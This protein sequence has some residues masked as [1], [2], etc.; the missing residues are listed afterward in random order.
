LNSWALPARMY[1]RAWPRYAKSAHPAFRATVSSHVES[2][3]PAQSLLARPSRTGLAAA[4]NGRSAGLNGDQAAHHGHGL[5]ELWVEHG[6]AEF[7]RRRAGTCWP[8][9]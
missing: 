6:G 3:I 1:A 8:G 7:R 9:T 4:C 2:A 5:L